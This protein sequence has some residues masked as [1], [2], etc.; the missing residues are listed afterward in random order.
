GEF[1]ATRMLAGNIAGQ[2][3]TVPQ[4]IW[5]Y[6]QA[7]REAPAGG[8]AVVSVAVGAAAMAA[9]LVLVRGRAAPGEE[10]GHA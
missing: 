9:S 5:S 3:R 2:T 10:D 7:G 1:G 4:A 6:F 8:L